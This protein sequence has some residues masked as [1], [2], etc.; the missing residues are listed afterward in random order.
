[1]KSKKEKIY[2]LLDWAKK[3][4]SI[5][6]TKIR[7]RKFPMLR[8]FTFR[9]SKS[10][11]KI[12]RLKEK[13][14]TI[15]GR[16]RSSRKTEKSVSRAAHQPN[17]IF[18]NIIKA[19]SSQVAKIK[20]P[21]L[22]SPQILKSGQLPKYLNKKLVPAVVATLIIGGVLIKLTSGVDA[23]AVEVDS[24]RIAIVEHKADAEKIVNTLKTA[25]AGLWK[26]NVEVKQ[27]LIFNS[28]KTR[29]FQIDN[30]V[31]LKNKLNK[32]LVFVATATGIKINGQLAVVVKDSQTAIN[33]MEQIK[34]SFKSEGL[35]IANVAFQEKVEFAEVP[36]SL[37]DVLPIDK[38]VQLIKQGKQEKS[39]H[40]VKEGESLWIIARSKD[41]RV[42]DLI[43][44]NPSL[45]EHLSLGQEI[46]L[47]AVEPM[48][49][50]L[51][52]GEQT[53]KETVPYKVVVEIDSKMNRGREKVKVKGQNGLRQVT[54]K[55]AM[56]NGSIVSKDVLKEQTIKT[57]KNQVVVRGKKNIVI[58]SRSTGGKV[59][60]PIV[61]RITSRF[62]SRWGGTHTGL[63]IDGFT[64]ER[65]GAAASGVVVSAGR[66]GGYGKMV[67]IKHGNGLTTRYAHL[68]KIEVSVGQ[69][70]DKGELIGRVGSTGH[71]TGSH[72]HFEVINGGNFLNPLKML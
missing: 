68:S 25:K 4:M 32:S 9:L 30:L 40:V 21:R 53:V 70:V 18:S 3:L 58:A 11:N 19:L 47:V 29:R 62:G 23:F 42:A 52:T 63:D 22:S 67:V 54:Y 65:I 41:M 55:I 33:V 66:D 31:V 20:L 8:L 28:I 7:S 13:Y 5:G 1:M 44:M 16:E 72:L 35:K 15:R 24:K 51:I 50:V 12:K 49:N 69:K 37:R 43:K 60:W 71:S 48:I 38:A 64:G 34:A 6:L 61:G 59:S 56:K 17:L 2:G 14:S 36:S 46:N 45:N 26:R 27:K 39:V 10:E 57:A